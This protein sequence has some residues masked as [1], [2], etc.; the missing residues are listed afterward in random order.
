MSLSVARL[1]R[2]DAHFLVILTY[3]LIKKNK[4]LCEAVRGV[5]SSGFSASHHT[6][7]C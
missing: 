5:V 6:P 3:E 7:S 1:L 2:G 4:L